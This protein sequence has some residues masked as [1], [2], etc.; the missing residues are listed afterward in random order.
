MTVNFFCVILGEAALTAAIFAS[1]TV[2]K[3]ENAEDFAAVCGLVQFAKAKVTDATQPQEIENVI[4]TLVAINFTL[5]DD[6]TRATAEKHK[7]KTWDQIQ[8]Q[9]TGATKYYGNHWQRWTRV[10]NLDS[11]SDEAKSL[12]EWAKQ[13][14]N[15]E[16]KKQ[17]AHLLNEA[18]ALKQ[19]T[20]AETDKLKAATITDLQTKALHG[21][22]GAS[23]QIKFT[24]S[25]RENFCG[26]GQTAGGAPG[27]GVKEGLYH[28]LLCLCAGETTDS[29]AG[30]GCCD[31]CNAAPNNAAWGQNADGTPRA[32]LL[33]AKCPKYMIPV[34]PTRAELSSRLAAFAARANQH[35]GSGQ[36]ETYTMGKVGGSGA[37]G[38]TGQV[39]GTNKGRC[40]KFSETQILG[41]DASLKWRTKLE[42]AATAWEARQDALNKL[43][44]VASKLQLINTSA[45]SL[46]Y[47]ESAH[48]AQQQPKTGTQT[49]A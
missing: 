9:H 32:I 5:M 19:A 42:Q 10:A 33:A 25:T 11:N 2:T 4:N 43:E 39:G 45:A 1:G 28:V 44:A 26:Q 17:I 18:L 27:T 37:E 49:Q 31:S 3:G 36:A 22:A 12:K 41:G 29:G 20:A 23:A 16:V 7:D 30:Q 8:E 48:I 46:L 24:E 40:A 6:Q 34:S 14:N 38:C 15:P 35:E 13:R 21:D 47:T